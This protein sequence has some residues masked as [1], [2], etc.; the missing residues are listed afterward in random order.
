MKEAHSAENGQ[1]EIFVEETK[2]SKILT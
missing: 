2:I 1:Q